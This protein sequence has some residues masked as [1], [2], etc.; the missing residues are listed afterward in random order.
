MRELNAK[1][2]IV[3]DLLTVAAP[4]ISRVPSASSISAS[5]LRHWMV[6]YGRNRLFTGRKSTVEEIEGLASDS[7]HRRIALY[8]LGGVGYV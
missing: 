1:S 2:M 4:T 8:G 3:A 5:A 6:P 7:G